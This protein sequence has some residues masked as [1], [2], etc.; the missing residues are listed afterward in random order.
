MSHVKIWI[1]AVCGTKERFPFFVNEIKWRVIHHIE[2][3]AKTKDIYISRI[4]GYTDH[5]HILF[6][7]NATMSVA[8]ALQLIKGES[9]FWINKNKITPT[10][11]QWAHEYYAASVDESSLARVRAYI[12]RQEEHHRKILFSEEYDKF[13]SEY[14]AEVQG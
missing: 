3:N 7:L 12:D 9:A 8:Q 6:G 13:M 2:E 4:N 5:L 14:N 11:F 10:P 1:H